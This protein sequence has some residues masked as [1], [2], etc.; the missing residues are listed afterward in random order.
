MQGI[1]TQDE[2][3]LIPPDLKRCQGEKHTYQP[4]RLGGSMWDVARCRAK[5]TVVITENKKPNGSMSL[6]NTCWK[7]AIEQLGKTFTVKPI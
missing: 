3:K 5:P 1:V 4:F 2:V 6:C 7:I